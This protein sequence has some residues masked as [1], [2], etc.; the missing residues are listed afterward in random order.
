MVYGALLFVCALAFLVL[1][2]VSAE[3]RAAAEPFDASRLHTAQNVLA[4][5]V[6]AL[7]TVVARL[8]PLAA[9]GLFVFVGIVYVV[10]ERCEIRVPDIRGRERD[11]RQAEKKRVIGAHRET[12][13]SFWHCPVPQS[14]KAGFQDADFLRV[15][16]LSLDLLARTRLSA[17]R[18]T[19]AMFLAV[20]K[21]RHPIVHLGHAVPSGPCLSE[22]GF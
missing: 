3:R 14:K 22:R 11:K 8:S 12:P 4:L 21:I 19:T 1:S 20:L 5:A 17:K 15:F 16:M 13:F 18:R 9:L 2:T 10:R 6:Y 7:G